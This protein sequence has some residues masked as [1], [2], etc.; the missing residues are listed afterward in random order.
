MTQHSQSSN[1][2]NTP[3]SNKLLALNEGIRSRKMKDQRRERARENEA[4]MERVFAFILY[5]R[6]E[7]SAQQCPIHHPAVPV[8]LN[9]GCVLS[10]RPSIPLLTLLLHHPL[11]SLF[12]CCYIYRILVLA[13]M[14]RNFNLIIHQSNALS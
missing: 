14:A 5:R 3:T 12:S 10:S 6:P 13:S 9:T 1:R 2:I 8:L 7:S 11:L 4:R